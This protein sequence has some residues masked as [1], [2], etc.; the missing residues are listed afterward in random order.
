M[1]WPPPLPKSRVRIPEFIKMCCAI[2]VPS[3]LLPIKLKNNNTKTMC[4][5]IWVEAKRIVSELLV[6]IPLEFHFDV[7]LTTTY[8]AKGLDHFPPVLFAVIAI[9]TSWL[10][11]DLRQSRSCLISIPEP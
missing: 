6:V 9:L 2:K 1:P 11:T 5:S 7:A 8:R 10:F 3:S 4:T